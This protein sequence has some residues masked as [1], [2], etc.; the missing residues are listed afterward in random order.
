MTGVFLLGLKTPEGRSR[1][2]KKPA[3]EAAKA[4]AAREE[5]DRN[6]GESAV[7]A[8][9]SSAR[10]VGKR[11]GVPVH[12]DQWQWTLAVYPA[13]HRGIRDSETAASF[14]E[15]REAFEGSWRKMAPKI[16]EAD[17]EEH[18]R[19]RAYTAW[20]YR[21]WET[22]CKLPTQMTS[23]RSQCYCGVTID[24]ARFSEHVAA[25]HMN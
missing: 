25:E 14:Q 3:A 22:G 5:K 2:A 7:P 6:S 23:D 21:M 19:Q 4:Q 9:A 1:L 10:R 15:V 16:T 13:S 8:S 24:T 20:K 12:V 11:A 17:R 18:R